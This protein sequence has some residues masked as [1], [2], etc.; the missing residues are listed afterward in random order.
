MTAAT[1]LP[2]ATHLEAVMGTV[3]GIVSPG[4]L[5]AGTVREA[6][7]VLHEADRVFS[8]WDPDSPMSVL[9]SGRAGPDDLDPGDAATI[10][11]VLDR[12]RLARELTAGAFDP[13]AMPGGVDPTGL[14]KGWAAGR[15]L[16]VLTAAGVAAAMV[17]AGGDIAVTGRPGP[18]PWRVGV[19]HPA[20]PQAYAAVVEVAAA[21]ATSGDYERPGQLIDP[22]TGRT[23]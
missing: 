11:V 21:I 17:N 18:L 13:W 23:A 14:V 3:V 10:A 20:Q 22:T 19:R 16:D 6:V 15:A 2:P 4:P 8:T 1:S 5:P 9:R 7:R 12:C